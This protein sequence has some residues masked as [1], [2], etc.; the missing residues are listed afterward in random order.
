MTPEQRTTIISYAK[1]LNSTLPAEDDEL[2]GLVVDIVG[3]RVLLY[4]NRTDLPATVERVISQLIVKAYQQTVKESTQ[5]TPE[6]AVSSVSD[7]GQS[8]SYRDRAVS[9]LASAGDEE[10]FGSFTGLLAPYRRVTVV[11]Q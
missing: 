1:K 3:D 9:F 7:N 6:Q 2:L 8:V 5:A 4:L 11:G 10:I